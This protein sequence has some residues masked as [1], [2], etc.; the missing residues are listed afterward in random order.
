MKYC[1][2]FSDIIYLTGLSCFPLNSEE[3]AV[4]AGA[5]F[6]CRQGGNSSVT[7]RAVCVGDLQEEQIALRALFCGFQECKCI[8]ICTASVRDGASYC[9]V[10]NRKS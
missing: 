5:E 2:L 1:V 8:N 4:P 6:L 3:K 10:V 9:L 7:A